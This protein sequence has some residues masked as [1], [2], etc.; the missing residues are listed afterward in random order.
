M[1]KLFLIVVVCLV[2]YGTGFAEEFRNQI[3][4]YDIEKLEEIAASI[5]SDTKIYWTKSFT[6]SMITQASEQAQL[7]FSYILI[8]QNGELIRQNNEIIRLLRKIAK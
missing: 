4:T 8:R 1:K 3:D 2:L 5:R 6:P 7:D